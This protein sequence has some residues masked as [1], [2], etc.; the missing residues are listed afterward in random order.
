MRTLDIL[1]L[2][3]LL[4]ALPCW[5]AADAAEAPPEAAVPGPE[6]AAPKPDDA[7][8]AEPKAPTAEDLFSEGRDALF[9]GQY[10]QAIELLTQAV[11]ADATKTSYRLHLARA[12]RYAGKD[13]EAV[14]HLEEILK[15]APDHIEAGQALGEIHSAAGRWKDVV[16]VLEPLLKYRHDYPTYSSA[17][18]TCR[19]ISS[20]WR[21]RRT[22]RP[23]GWGWTAPCCDTSSARPISTCGTTSDGS[24]CRRFAPGSRARSTAGGT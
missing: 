2:A 18:F 4:L 17:T 20:P 11:Q 1:R 19:A 15:T 3:V 23:C 22:S 21:P 5:S 9:K 16:R 7:A 14:K 6:A 13:D 12:Y 10:D 8:D 24:P